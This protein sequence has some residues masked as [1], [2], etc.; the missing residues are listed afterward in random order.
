M[1]KDLSDFFYP[2]NSNDDIN[3]RNFMDYVQYMAEIEREREIESKRE[4]KD[5]QQNIT[6]DAQALW[7]IQTVK[8]ITQE[9]TTWSSEIAV[10]THAMD[11]HTVKK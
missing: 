8:I 4:R 5:K 10:T 1:Y 3:T 11:D 2:L 7:L 6:R 9:T